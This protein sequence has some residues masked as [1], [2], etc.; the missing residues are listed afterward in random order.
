MRPALMGRITRAGDDAGMPIHDW[1]EQER[2]REKLATEATA[3]PGVRPA[4]MGRITRAGDDAGMPIH[5][6]P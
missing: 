6:W 4:L 3:Y 1:P 2:P 5:D